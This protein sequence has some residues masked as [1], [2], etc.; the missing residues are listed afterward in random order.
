MASI[1]FGQNGTRPYCTLTVTEQSQSIPNNSTIVQYTLTLVRPMAITSSAT[2]AW[3][4]TINGVNHAGSGTIGG[5]GNKILLSGTQTIQH[6]AD[7]T[8]TIAFSG[9]CQ[10]DINWG[11][12]QIGTISGNGSMN[13]TTIPRYGVVSQSLS[14]KTETTISVN[15]SS[16]AVADFMWYST[17][18]GSTWTEADIADASKGSYTISG[19]SANTTYNIKT[20]VRRKDSQLTSDSPTLAVVTYAYPYASSMPNFTIGASLTIGL[21][22]PL[23]RTVTVALIGSDNSQIAIETATS[24]QITGYASETAINGLYASIPNSKNGTYK[25]KVTY[26]TNSSTKTGGAYSVNEN[27]CMPLIGGVA[28]RDTNNA[29]IAL[30][31]N[32]QDIVRNHSTVQFTASDLNGQRSASIVS[33]RVTVNGE[34]YAMALSGTSATGGNATIDSGM[35][36]AA[37]ITVTDSRGLSTSKKMSVNMLDW[38]IPSGIISLARQHNY[39]SETD[40]KVDAK[41]AYI[42]GNNAI[43]ITYQA[44]EDSPAR[45]V[46]S[47]T[48]QDNV[49]SEIVL[50][51]SYAWTVVVTLRDSLG[52]TANYTLFISRG[53]PIVYFDRLKNSIGM[54]CF[55]QHAK[56]LE[57]DGEIYIN[58]EPIADYVIEQGKQGNWN[59]RKYAS[60]HVECWTTYEIDSA[61]IT[62]N[63][64]LSTGLVYGN[65]R[66][67]NPFDITEAV[68]NA[69]LDYCGGNVGWVSTAHS[70]DE[71][72]NSITVVRNGNTGTINTSISINGKWR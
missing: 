51:N 13:L 21:Y 8:K 56:T 2:K 4:V 37:T 46:V 20:R 11:G 31:G 3:S 62:W 57:I 43:T 15:W 42:N 36:L 39:Y 5:S 26:G 72:Q 16:D 67:N 34:T 61:N 59:Y 29:T 6:N 27:V 1:T 68:V 24:N 10:L 40:I 44:T 18:N 12:V 55:P 45:T 7:G 70:L 38:Y 63:A 58:S 28:Y 66:V 48:L 14:A 69:S 47:G 50:D 60:G 19:L 54:N 41:Y 65:F 33:C 35:D 49:T 23:N 32:N 64:Y 52:G 22:N 9:K 17:D 53:M 25:V 71:S 30:T